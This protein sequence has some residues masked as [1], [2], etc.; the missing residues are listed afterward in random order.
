MSE[1][2]RTLKI[3]PDLFK[4]NRKMKKVKN[5]S[6]KNKVKPNTDE[7][8]SSK[9]KKLKKEMMKKVK[10]YQRTKELEDSR[11]KNEINNNIFEK[12]IYENNDFDREFNKSL[13]F[14]Q[15][16]AK[17]NKDKKKKETQ[18]NIRS[19]IDINLNLPES[20]KM[21]ENNYSCLKNGSKPT[22]KQLNK[23]QKNS[24]NYKPKVRIILENNVYDDK[25]I[26][27]DNLDKNKRSEEVGVGVGVEIKNKK[28][29]FSEVIDN[30]INKINN[31][32]EINL[33][34]VSSVDKK[35]DVLS[36][37]LIS[38]EVFENFKP[39]KELNDKANNISKKNELIELSNK[40]FNNE[41]NKE[42]FLIK[43]HNY[44]SLIDDEEL[45]LKLNSIPKINRI[46][47]KSTYKLGKNKNK[48]KVG[49][50]VKNRETQKNIK[51][52]LGLLKRKSIQEVKDYLKRKNLIKIGSDTP[53]D[54]LR[55]IYEDSILSGD[56]TN[57]NNNNIIH[58]YLN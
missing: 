56:I 9:A 58:N 4:L 13:N 47:K 8:N 12:N 52:E 41:E 53:N 42:D 35:N 31:I 23:T 45:K 22:Y 25:E 14:L 57:I 19:D 30:K 29:D 48:N 34:E 6:L 54:V 1:S 2:N 15:D 11:E 21:N 33:S 18:K 17:K 46:T 40:P 27:L 5:K 50:L 24:D 7:E 36:N 38:N 28:E 51:Q 20:L 39:L 37:E 44:P 55:K 26:R 10:D 32:N 16:L 43:R 49:I 3:N